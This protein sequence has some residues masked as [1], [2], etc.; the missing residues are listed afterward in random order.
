M[1]REGLNTSLHRFAAICRLQIEVEAEQVFASRPAEPGDVDDIAEL[2]Y[3]ADTGINGVSGWDLMFGGPRELLLEKIK[4]VYLH[5][6]LTGFHYS[7]FMVGEDEGRIVG[8]LAVLKRG[9]DR[10]LGWW[11]TLREMGVS[12]PRILSLAWKML[13]FVLV[14]PSIPRDTL[15]VESAAV[16]PDCRGNELAAEGL[17]HAYERAVAGGYRRIQIAIVIGNDAPRKACE[18]AGFQVKDE[19][20]SRLFEKRFG[21]PGMMRMVLELPEA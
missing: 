2:I 21:A 1:R 5:G 16:F 12:V 19:Y 6:R 8:A 9:D 10:L 15:V 4:W 20:R 7:K 14:N 17:K 11:K 3:I 13:P 18:K